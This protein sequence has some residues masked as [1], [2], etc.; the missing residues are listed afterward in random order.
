MS[1]CEKKFVLGKKIMHN[2]H[3]LVRD[4]FERH[5]VW[6]CH[7]CEGVARAS[8]LRLCR[9]NSNASEII[10]ISSKFKP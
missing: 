3:N 2:F 1:F 6:V 10:T 4:D 9:V 5:S 7:V 8:Q